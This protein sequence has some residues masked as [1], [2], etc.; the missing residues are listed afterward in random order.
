MSSSS[1]E[2]EPFQ[3]R[4]YDE[5][6]DEER[7]NK[8]RKTVKTLRGRGIGFVSSAAPPKADAEQEEDEDDIDDDRPTMGGFRNSFNIGEFSGQTER[9]ESPPPSMGAQ[10]KPQ[11]SG[12]SAFGRG[13]KI[14]KNSFAARMMARQ[15]YVEGQGLGKAGQGITAPIQAKGTAN[16]AGLGTGTAPEPPRRQQREKGTS[17]KAST[18]GTTT[19]K[20]R[21]PPKTKYTVAAIESRGLHVPEA[22]KSIIIDATGAKNK[23]VDSLSGFSTP[24]REQSPGLETAKAAA[25]VKMQVQAYAEAWDATKDQETRLDQEDTQVQAA[26]RLHDKEAQKYQDLISAFERVSADDSSQPREWYDINTRL[27]SIQE[28]YNDHIDE[29]DL[30]S[31]AV[32]C[33]E[34]PFRQILVEWD[35]LTQAAPTDLITSLQSLTS[36]LSI[37]KSSTSNHPRK[38]TTAFESLLLLHWYPTVLTALKSWSVYDPDPAFSL[39]TTWQPVLP[40]W[41]V[42]KLLHELIL[43]KLLEAVRRFPKP[44]D[45]SLTQTPTTNGTTRRKTAPDLHT[46]LFDWWTLLSSSSLELERF[47]EL[48]SLVK[49][50][51]TSSTWPIWKPLLGS[52]KRTITQGHPS[53]TTSASRL[54]AQPS[55]PSTPSAT[56]AVEEISFKS[57]VEEWCTE[58]NLL[59]LNTNRSNQLGR[60]LYRLSD[61]ERRSKG[62]LVY[63]LDDVVFTS[64]D[65]VPWALD[66]PLVEKARQ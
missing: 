11:P 5:D 57:L 26:I 42:Y 50:K 52:D 65:D 17:S 48:R 49:T 58:H 2:G 61:A 19:P 53:S 13:G 33:L 21:A 40:P 54:A 66:E 25:R 9:D 28:E 30:P 32:S 31:L 38:R 35:P 27:M 29:L 60:L 36:I 22:M 1:D 8:R 64:E 63:L 41:L 55:Q 23:H 39:I 18:P 45:N 12:P 15:G 43:P 7:P 46:W 6:T 44:V 56:A 59:L 4:D 20:I 47:P 51:L 10:Q 62:V 24:T 37:P 34:S 14:Q 3:L 16:R